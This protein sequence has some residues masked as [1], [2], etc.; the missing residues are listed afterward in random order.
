MKTLLCASGRP[1]AARV[2]LQLGEPVGGTEWYVIEEETRALEGT[3]GIEKSIQS[4]KKL[5][6]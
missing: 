3:E 6:A 2:L 1:G 4:L 5:L